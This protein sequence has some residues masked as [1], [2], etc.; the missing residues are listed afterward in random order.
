MTFY[1]HHFNPTPFVLRTNEFI[2]RGL[3]LSLD[4]NKSP[5]LRGIECCYYGFHGSHFVMEALPYITEDYR[6]LW[7]NPRILSGDYHESIYKMAGQNCEWPYG[8]F[9]CSE[10]FCHYVHNL[11]G[12]S[13]NIAVKQY[14]SVAMYELQRYVKSYSSM[15]REVNTEITS[16]LW[17]HS[18]FDKSLWRGQ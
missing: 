7:W 6:E 5:R 12:N 15:L 8:A 11:T 2:S 18:G 9:E 13:A 3:K 10:L 16:L 14:P 17:T 1:V 4:L